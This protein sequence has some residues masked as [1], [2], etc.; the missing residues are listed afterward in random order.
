MA[1]IRSKGNKSTEQALRYRMVR[2]GIRGWHMLDASI[3]GKP[4][5]VF[6]AAELLVFVD[7]CYWH[8]CP[9]CYRAPGSNQE[10]W[11]EKVA[12]NIRRDRF[13]VKQ[14]K[15]DGWRILRVWEHEMKKCPDAV[16]AKIRALV[17]PPKRAFSAS[18]G[19]S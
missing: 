13:V 9:K 8:G 11:S 1:A 17:R 18:A 6:K 12:R 10:F 3:L 15:K 4:D 5:F 16:V 19:R 14:L 2:A 7:G